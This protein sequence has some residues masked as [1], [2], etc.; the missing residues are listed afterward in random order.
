MSDPTEV[1]A[2]S[3]REFWQVSLGA[4]P[5]CATGLCACDKGNPQKG[6]SVPPTLSSESS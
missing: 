2:G 1:I 3:N 6:G 4:S 5:A